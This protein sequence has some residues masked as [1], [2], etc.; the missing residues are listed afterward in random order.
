VSNV[1]SSRA[2]G[3]SVL[4]FAA[5]LFVVSWTLNARLGSARSTGLASLASLSVSVPSA[6]AEIPN[7]ELMLCYQGGIM[8]WACAPGSGVTCGYGPTD[9]GCADVQY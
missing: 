7:C 5:L 2:S 1:H 4:L 3:A 9:C 6:T 8:E